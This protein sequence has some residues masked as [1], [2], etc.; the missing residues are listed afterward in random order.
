MPLIGDERTPSFTILDE[1]G[2]P[3]FDEGGPA[4][5]DPSPVF[6]PAPP[7]W[8]TLAVG[9]AGGNAP[10]Q[11]VT[12]FDTL[13]VTDS[14][15]DGPSCTY[16]IPGDSPAAKVIDGLAT[17]TWLYRV[18][19]QGSLPRWQ[20][21]RIM[22]IDQTWDDNGGDVAQIHAVGY[23]QVVA[24]RHIIAVD[25]TVNYVTASGFGSAQVTPLPIFEGVDQGLIVAALVAHTQAQLGG[26][27]GITNAQSMLTGQPRDRTQYKVGD[28]IGKLLADLGDVINGI[29]WGVDVDKVLSVRLWTDFNTLVTPIVHGQNATTIA[30][31]RARFANAAGAQGSDTVTVPVWRTDPTIATDPRGRWEV[32]DASHSDVIDQAVVADYAAAELEEFSNPPTTWKATIEPAAYFTGDS[33]Y[34]PGDVTNIV[35]PADAVDELG[36]PKVNATALITEVTVAYTDSGAA[37]V[38]VAAVEVS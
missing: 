20:R 35:V 31:T 12:A 7:P 3:F 26:N 21:L 28:E 14:L 18:P 33:R 34:E 19:L 4:T 15:H 29:W 9:P 27:L 5:P 38:T 10:T 1:A 17:D 36:Q 6:P 22:P 16:N 23:K 24:A 13:T 25:P 8:L 37:T 11:P 2:N 32:Y 30:R